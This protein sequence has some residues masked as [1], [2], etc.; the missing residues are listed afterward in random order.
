M[1]GTA[2]VYIIAGQPSKSG[3][4]GVADVSLALLAVGSPPSAMGWW[5]HMKL[6][7]KVEIDGFSP[8]PARTDE[9]IPPAEGE[10]LE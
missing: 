8:P 6:K 9:P 7:D 4:A 1:A 2:C 5:L 10:A 3:Q